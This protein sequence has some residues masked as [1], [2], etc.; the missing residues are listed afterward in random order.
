MVTLS[1]AR[2]PSFRIGKSVSELNGESHRIGANISGLTFAMVVGGNA[3]GRVKSTALYTLRDE[4]PDVG[5]M[6]VKAAI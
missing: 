5:S 6:K 3:G 1:A 2:A 4:R